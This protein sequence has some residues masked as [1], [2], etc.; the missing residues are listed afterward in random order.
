MVSPGNPTFDDM[1]SQARAL[2]DQEKPLCLRFRPGRAIHKATKHAGKLRVKRYSSSATVS[3]GT[4]RQSQS[5]IEVD[6]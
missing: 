2:T 3:L 4:H 1:H 6:E 5:G